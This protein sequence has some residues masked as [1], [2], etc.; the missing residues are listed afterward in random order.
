MKKQL[1]NYAAILMLISFTAISCKKKSADNTPLTGTW[2]ATEWITDMNNNGII[3]DSDFALNLGT[4]SDYEIAVFT[5]D[6][7]C[8]NHVH[9]SSYGVYD[10]TLTFTWSLSA[11]KQWLTATPAPPGITSAIHADTL[12]ATE[13]VIS[14]TSS[15]DL[16]KHWKKFKKQ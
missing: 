15:I 16:F 13:V 4:A 14:Y 8:T 10:T 1:L 6:H 12:T 7:K 3:D 9:I 2:N 11:D 5:N